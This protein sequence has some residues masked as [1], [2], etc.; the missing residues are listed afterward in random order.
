VVPGRGLPCAAPYGSAQS[1]V[2][3]R[4]AAGRASPGRHAAALNEF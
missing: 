1:S 4:P 3:R 2:E